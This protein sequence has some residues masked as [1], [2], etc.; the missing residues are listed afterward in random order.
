MPRHPYKTGNITSLREFLG[1]DFGVVKCPVCGIEGVLCVESSPD[2]THNYLVVVH[3]GS[4]EE[5]AYAH[6]VPLYL[7]RLYLCLDYPEAGRI[8]EVAKLGARAGDP[9]IVGNKRLRFATGSGVREVV[10]SM[11]FKSCARYGE[12]HTDRAF[13]GRAL[14]AELEF[15]F[16]GGELAN[17]LRAQ[18]LLCDCP[19]TPG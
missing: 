9:Y 8:I 12:L 17:V 10:L 15:L 19:C 13:R 2:H 7:S 11:E 14:R 3:G 6:K 4:C 1:V 5:R 16:R 18:G